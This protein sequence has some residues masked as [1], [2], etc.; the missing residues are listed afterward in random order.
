M[1][2]HLTC[3]RYWSLLLYRRT[4]SVNSEGLLSPKT[5]LVNLVWMPKGGG[6]DP[7]SLK[8]GLSSAGFHMLDCQ[9]RPWGECQA[10]RRRS[11][12]PTGFGDRHRMSQRSSWCFTFTLH[13]ALCTSNVTD[14][15]CRYL[16]PS[17]QLISNAGQTFGE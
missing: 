12:S 5:F 4:V 3:A 1:S 6:F 15:K 16:V 13:F 7:G 8:A 17:S 11:P 10:P 9:H 2:L 14:N